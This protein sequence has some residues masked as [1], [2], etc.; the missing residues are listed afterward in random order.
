MKNAESGAFSAESSAKT[1]QILR[2]AESRLDSATHFV[3]SSFAESGGKNYG[4]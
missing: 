4:I 1:M 3:E 2:I